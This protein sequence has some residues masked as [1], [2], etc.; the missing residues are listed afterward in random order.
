MYATGIY[1]DAMFV[2][3]PLTCRPEGPLKPQAGHYRPC[4]MVRYGSDGLVSTGGDM[5]KFLEYS[6]GRPPGGRMSRELLLQQT[7]VV[8]AP[9]CGEVSPKPGPLDLLRLVP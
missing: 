2:D 9:H 3:L 5:L 7:H 4:P 6:M 1:Y 8:D